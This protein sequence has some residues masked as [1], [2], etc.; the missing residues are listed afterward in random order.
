MKGN[1]AWRTNKAPSRLDIE[2]K[3]ILGNVAFSV[4]LHG[5]KMDL[6][7]L[8]QVYEAMVVSVMLYS[9]AQAGQQL[10]YSLISLMFVTVDI[11]EQYSM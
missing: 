5:K 4:W 8:I 6:S 11:L 7:R 1:E 2:R 9:S 10:R 3:C